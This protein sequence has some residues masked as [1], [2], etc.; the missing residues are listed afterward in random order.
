VNP[1]NTMHTITV[2]TITAEP[3]RVHKLNTKNKRE[4]LT[5]AHITRLLY[6]HIYPSLWRSR[7]SRTVVTFNCD[8]RHIR[9]AQDMYLD[10]GGIHWILTPCHQHFSVFTPWDVILYLLPFNYYSSN[11]IHIVWKTIKNK[12]FFY[13]EYIKDCIWKLLIIV[14]VTDFV[15]ME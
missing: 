8:T 2:I 15:R 10:R 3:I 13:I 4:V 1:Y 7:W 9:N 6:I 5:S 11:T 12:R 14:N